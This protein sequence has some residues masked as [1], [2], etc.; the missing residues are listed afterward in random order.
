VTSA[1]TER[2]RE[3]LLT[4]IVVFRP[5]AARVTSRLSRA[6]AVTI[7]LTEET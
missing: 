3:T 5:N 7:W 1:I 6:R 2:R 4:G